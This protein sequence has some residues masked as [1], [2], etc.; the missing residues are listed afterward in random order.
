MTKVSEIPVFMSC[1]T[2][3]MPKTLDTPI[4]NKNKNK[5]KIPALYCLNS[6][7]FFASFDSLGS[8]KLQKGLK[9][10]KEFATPQDQTPQSSQGLSYQ[11]RSTHGS[12][13]ICSRGQPC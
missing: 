12:S 10:L 5:N 1:T 4:K 3:I 2:I 13:C 9:E 8:T 6:L 11:P 7:L